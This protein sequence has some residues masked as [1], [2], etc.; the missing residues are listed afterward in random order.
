MSQ[1]GRSEQE[2]GS[3][4]N[5]LGDEALQAERLEDVSGF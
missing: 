3:S 4:S 5:V 1:L 2:M